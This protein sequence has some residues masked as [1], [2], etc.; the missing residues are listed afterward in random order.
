MIKPD[1]IKIDFERQRATGLLRVYDFIDHDNYIA[2][3]PS[4]NLS[5]YASTKE[6]ALKRLFE[7]VV[8]D[9]FSTLTALPEY[10]ATEELKKLGWSRGKILKKKFESNT[11]ID[12]DGI[13]KNFNLSEE[14]EI[15]DELVTV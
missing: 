15:H 13:L 11:F 12:R 6:E 1:S 4:L 2:F 8:D 10:K 14:T 5:A 9:F 3:I 7:V